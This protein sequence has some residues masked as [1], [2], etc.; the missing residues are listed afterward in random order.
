MENSKVERPD[1]K[2]AFLKVELAM[3]QNLRVT[4]LP[5]INEEL[6]LSLKNHIEII[7]KTRQFDVVS[8]EEFVDLFKAYVSIVRYMFTQRFHK[9]LKGKQIAYAQHILKKDRSKQFLSKF[10][11]ARKHK[12]VN[13]DEKK[14]VDAMY[15]LSKIFPEVLIVLPSIERTHQ[16]LHSENKPLPKPRKSRNKRRRKMTEEDKWRKKMLARYGEDG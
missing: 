2:R 6:N 4:D 14:F 13:D 9:P 10:F 12:N 1:Y 16:R 11:H 7:C 8:V 5:Q 3:K 15:E